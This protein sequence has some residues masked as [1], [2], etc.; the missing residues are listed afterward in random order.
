MPPQ[1]HVHSPQKENS[2]NDSPKKPT[3]PFLEHVPHKVIDERSDNKT[4]G[5]QNEEV[6]DSREVKRRSRDS[7]SSVSKSPEHKRERSR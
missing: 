6:R 3:N 1:D 7:F 2:E 5:N 4:D